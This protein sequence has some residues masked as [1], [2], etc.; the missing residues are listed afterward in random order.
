M[1]LFGATGWLQCMPG[2]ITMQCMA[3]LTCTPMLTCKIQFA[4]A[5]VHCLQVCVASG[6]AI[7]DP[8]RDAVRCKTCK[9][10][11][12]ISEARALTACP[13]CHS[14]LAKMGLNLQGGSGGG[15]SG[16]GGMG[17]GSMYANVGGGGGGG[18]GSGGG[19]SA[20]MYANVGGGGGGMYAGVGGGY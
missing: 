5:C 10:A 6:R 9:H 14:D 12:I 8:S 19:S 16:R 1:S 20:G 17:G 3:M 18:G 4:F 2:A 13:L 7:K 15:G 11:I